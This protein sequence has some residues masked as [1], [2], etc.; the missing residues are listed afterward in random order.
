[1]YIAT[2]A[3]SSTTLAMPRDLLIEKAD[4]EEDTVDQVISILKAEFE[5]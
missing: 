3:R 5:D 2:P 1:M 4:L